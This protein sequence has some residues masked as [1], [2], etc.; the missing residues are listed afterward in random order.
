MET[1]VGA[2]VG[3]LLAIAGSFLGARKSFEY[4]EKENELN[5]SKKERVYSLMLYREIDQLI[6]SRVLRINN[7]ISIYLKEANSE[8]NP[9]FMVRAIKIIPD[10]VGEGDWKAQRELASNSVILR[11]EKENRYYYIES[12]K[13]IKITLLHLIDI[14]DVEEINLIYDIDN[15]LK[16][17]WFLKKI[18]KKEEV[19]IMIEELG[20]TNYLIEHSSKLIKIQEKLNE[21]SNLEQNIGSKEN[22]NIE[23]LKEVYNLENIL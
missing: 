15:K 18:S 10:A 12:F 21:I 5:K 8:V 17:L 4:Q 1:L 11:E 23:K 9:L 6:F 20:L 13:D 2:I 7:I 22:K 3:G 14:L 16:D 19:D